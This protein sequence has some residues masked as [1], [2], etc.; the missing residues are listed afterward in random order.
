MGKR[1]RMALK[2]LIL[3]LVLGAG[4]GAL[5]QSGMLPESVADAVSSLLSPAADG[6]VTRVTDGDT[7]VVEGTGKVRIIGIDTMDSFNQER[8]ESQTAYYG[9]SE[10]EVRMW[11]RV[12]TDYVQ[13]QIDGRV[14]KLQYGPDST[15]RYGRTLAYVHLPDGTDLGL[16]LIER[17]YATA[18]RKYSHPRKE[19]YL[20]AEALARLANNGLW[21]DATR[22]DW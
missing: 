18:Y 12:A 9:M 15:D 5:E 20:A 8:V 4:L 7:I 22:G 17:G 1:R 16:R 10:A 6:E 11:S 3:A 14:V 13:E 19:H 2:A 21:E